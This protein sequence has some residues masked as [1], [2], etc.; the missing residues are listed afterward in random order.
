MGRKII[1]LIGQRFGRLLVLEEVGRDKYKHT[2]W[3]CRCS[4]GNKK[5]IVVG[6]LRRG[7]TKSCGCYQKERVSETNTTH[8]LSHTKEC[9]KKWRR[10]KQ[11]GDDPKYIFKSL[12]ANAKKRGVLFEWTREEWMEWYPTQSRVCVYCEIPIGRVS[13]KGSVAPNAISIDRKNNDKGY[14]VENC[15]LC[16]R[17][18]NTIKNKVFSYEEM[19]EIGQKYMKPKWQ[20]TAS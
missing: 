5:V 14:S 20:S 18:C 17:K 4:C 2:T 1:N 12:K 7:A 10:Q 15:V 13:G 6:S 9:D 19:L 16:C 8:G 3:L 11:S